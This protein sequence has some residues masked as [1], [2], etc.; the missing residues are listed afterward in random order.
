MDLHRT[1]CRF[2]VAPALALLA[3]CGSRELGPTTGPDEAGT[4]AVENGDLGLVVT[5]VEPART[6]ERVT[7]QYARFVAGLDSLGRSAPLPAPDALRDT[8]RLGTRMGFYREMLLLPGEFAAD[9]EEPA[10]GGVLLPRGGAPSLVASVPLLDGEA[11]APRGGPRGIPGVL[12]WRVEDDRV[13]LGYFGADA[14]EIAGMPGVAVESDD[15][16]TLRLW[17]VPGAERARRALLGWA[18]A[19]RERGEVGMVEE[20]VFAAASTALELLSDVD[21]LE[22][23]LRVGDPGQPAL[24]FHAEV[25]PL[26]G[27]HLASMFPNEPP[28]GDFPF[29]G[30]IP[31]GARSFAV[32]RETP[33]DDALIETTADAVER[34]FG[35]F[36]STARP[37]L[38]EHVAALG[39]ATGDLLRLLDGRWLDASWS[40]DEGDP[41]PAA[42]DGGELFLLAAVGNL[43]RRTMVLGVRDEDAA[44]EAARHACEEIRA[45]GEFLDE[46]FGGPLDVGCR[47]EPASDGGGEVDVLTLREKIA[48][49]DLEAGRRP[50]SADV[51]YASGEARLVMVTGKDWEERLGWALDDSAPGGGLGGDPG[52]LALRGRAPETAGSLARIDLA[53]AVLSQ[54]QAGG[55]SLAGELTPMPL[56]VWFGVEDG[57]AVLRAETSADL[58]SEAA[59]L[60]AKLGELGVFW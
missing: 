20:M 30:A 31:A 10:Y 22:A 24:S 1:G 29:L 56:D 12:D 5:L 18:A 16:F 14:V 27:S 37:D 46:M 39:A 55:T 4:P 21:S 58:A 57:R 42:L 38:A 50:W 23:G 43:P 28:A 60:F 41:A 34:L 13:A 15:D 9:L 52:W 59:A 33:G 35:A 40:A 19:M 53:T 32:S 49:G 36:V 2:A 47:R 17:G 11:S 3:A 26:A 25:K 8:M 7:A 44:L 45:L 54:F 48:P 51:Y 6:I